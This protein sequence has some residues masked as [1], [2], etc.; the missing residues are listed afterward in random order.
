VVRDLTK[1]PPRVERIGYGMR[2]TEADLPVIEALGGRLT[3]IPLD[4]ADFASIEIAAPVVRDLYVDAGLATDLRVL[5]SFTRLERLHVQAAK[6]KFSVDLTRLPHLR[7]YAGRFRNFESVLS[8][9]TLRSFETTRMPWELVEEFEAPLEEL[10]LWHARPITEVPQL[11]SSSALRWLRMNGCAEL[12][13][14]GLRTYRRT[15]RTLGLSDIGKVTSAESLLELNLESL[16]IGDCRNIEP[17]D[18]LVT[19]DF[20][21][22]GIAGSNVF[23]TA[24]RSQVRHPEKWSFPPRKGRRPSSGPF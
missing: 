8:V 21:E 13:L 19:L 17:I 6:S 15:L 10:E 5:E 4:V 7:S 3:F 9:G 22:I 14:S 18:P 16:G 12:D 24:F 2:I 23:D 11:K 20:P 1:L